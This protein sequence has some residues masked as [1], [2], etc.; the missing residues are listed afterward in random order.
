MT[1]NRL[2]GRFNECIKITPNKLLVSYSNTKFSYKV[3]LISK[4]TDS[5]M[6]GISC[7]R[8]PQVRVTPCSLSFL[9]SEVNVAKTVTV[10]VSACQQHTKV[11]LIDHTIS[12]R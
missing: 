8:Y 5:L 12:Q 10:D 2:Q 6:I 1:A 7:A 11:V 3:Q 4:L 9:L